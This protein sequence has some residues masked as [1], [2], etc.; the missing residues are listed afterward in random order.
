MIAVAI[1]GAFVIG[2]QEV[3]A[4]SFARQFTAV[5]LLG[6]ALTYVGVTRSA[7]AQLE[8]YGNLQ[9]LQRSRSDQ[10]RSESGF[11]QRR[12][13][14]EHLGRTF[15]NSH[16]RSLFAL[17][18]F[19]LADHFFAPKHHL[20]GDGNLVGFISPPGAWAVVCHQVS[21]AND[22]ADPDF[23]GDADACLFGVSGQCGQRPIASGLSCWCSILY[24]WRSGYVLMKE[25][26]EERKRRNAEERQRLSQR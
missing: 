19:S 4:T 8:R 23:Y 24:S 15:Y 21:L 17:C 2:M 10:A 26:R 14:F 13:C 12:R 5:I 9:V 7:G 6:L 3:T 11:G 22:L 1:A 18:A 20:A 16:G 25:K